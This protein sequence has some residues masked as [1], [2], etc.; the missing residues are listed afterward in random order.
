MTTD[1]SRPD[2]PTDERAE[3]AVEAADPIVKN[4][5]TTDVAHSGAN[6]DDPTGAKAAGGLVNSDIDTQAPDEGSRRA[7]KGAFGARQ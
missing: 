1:Q 6:D 5:S 3:E 4:Y 7:G 2:S